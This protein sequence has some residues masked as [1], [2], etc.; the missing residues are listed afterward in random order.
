MAGAGP[1][2]GG[3]GSRPTDPKGLTRALAFQDHPHGG[4]AGLVQAGGGLTSPRPKVLMRRPNSEVRRCES[5]V[6]P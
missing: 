1:V 4:G 6:N 2:Q 5:G 3:E